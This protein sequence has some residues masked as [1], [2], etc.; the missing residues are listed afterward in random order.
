MKLAALTLLVCACSLMAAAPDARA[1][2]E[3][4]PEYG[5]T[6]EVPPSQRK[7]LE[8]HLDLYRWRGS[9]R[10]TEAQLQRLVRLAPTQIRDFLATEGY[11][12][13]RIEAAMAQKD[14]KWL[15][16]LDVAPGEPARVASMDFQVTGPFNDGSAENNDRLAKLR[17]DWSLPPGAVFRQDDWDSA[18]RGALTALLLE[19]YPTASVTDSRATVNPET[20]SVEL[21]I[22]LES[23][24]A[25][26]FGALEIKGLN[27]YP[28]SLVEHMNP[29]AAGAPYSQAKL[30][31]L[32]SRLQDSTYFSAAAV[33]VDKDTEHP[34]GMPVRIEVTEAPSKKLG[35]GL[36]ASTDTGARG[37]MDYR[38]LNF[39]GRAWRLGGLFKL[40]QKQQSFGGD[41]QFPQSGEGHR[42]SINAQ[43]ERTD[44]KGEVTQKLSMGAKRNFVHGRTETTWGLRYMTE[45]Q[46]ISGAGST[47]NATL[48]PSWAWT[49]RNVNHLLYPTQG[50]LVNLQADVS[51]RAL[52]S[53]Q[54]F[55]RAYGHAAY[56]QP[57]GE[58]DQLILRG[59]LGVVA[60]RSRSGI[61]SDYLFRTGGDQ[62][63]R[64]YAY[65]SLGVQE[66]SAIVGGRYLAVASAE[67]VHWL[68]AR[69]GGAVFVD[70][71][72]A[73][74]SLRDMTPV[75]G[76]GV[77]ARWK[78]PV[79][80]LNLDIAYGQKAREVHLH[81]SVGFSF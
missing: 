35:F 29:I 7:L 15:V 10:M 76:Y 6:L 66:G 44:I 34:A 37:Q 24:P 55:L 56:F 26:T 63:V 16:T 1:G 41:L 20:K 22:I 27:R 73:A 57:L 36:G 54:D 25:F 81:F 4:I 2:D 58:R 33:S 5:I 50:Y 67:Y 31:L 40:E 12:S 32:Q 75:R 71:G 62:T 53:D 48:S 68:T 60:A 46:D 9:E 80:P 14:G 21:R 19:R 49:L 74:D 70:A 39:L 52:L 79:G 11:F 65:Q 77:G 30:L 28:T 61:P 47:R 45:R 72:N 42:D 64:G 43:L 78:S 18:K 69:W 23:G 3:A 59:E 13:P 8:D 51:T 17:S 38:D